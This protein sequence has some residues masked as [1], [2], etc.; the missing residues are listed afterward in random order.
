MNAEAQFGYTIRP[1]TAKDAPALGLLF[2]AHLQALG[3]TPD[4]GLDA[5]MANYMAVYQG[6]ANGFLV[7]ESNAED[8][9]GMVGMG[10]MADGIIRRLHVSEKWR[11]H[12]VARALVMRLIEL[13]CAASSQPLT[14]LVVGWNVPARRLFL[15]CGFQ[16]TRHF[17]QHPKMSGCEMLSFVG[18]CPPQRCV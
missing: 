17:S 12:G 4:A 7:A 3:A 14:A 13:H 10:G 15:S 8:V 9:V 11:G 18:S 5:D 6:A 2:A 16:P 1:A